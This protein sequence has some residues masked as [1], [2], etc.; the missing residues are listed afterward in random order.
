VADAVV[1]W[2]V[3][4]HEGRGAQALGLPDRN[5]HAGEAAA[6]VQRFELDVDRLA[7][8]APAHEQRLDGFE[9]LG[10]HRCR[11][12]EQ[13]LGEE[14]ATEDDVA[15]VC[16]GHRIEAVAVLPTRSKT[17]LSGTTKS[18]AISL[19][20]D[21]GCRCP[22]RKHSAGSAWHPQRRLR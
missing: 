18:A 19:L 14:L 16:A 11:R 7:D 22:V 17:K 10:R 15:R 9:R 3:Q 5:V 12:G 13:H 1:F 21:V 4:Q 6:V 8:V 20:A 2:G